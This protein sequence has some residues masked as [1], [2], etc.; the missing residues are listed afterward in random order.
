MQ[1]SN[2][3]DNLLNYFGYT[4]SAEWAFTTNFVTP[5]YESTLLQLSLDAPSLRNT[6]EVLFRYPPPITTDSCPDTSQESFNSVERSTCYTGV[7]SS[8]L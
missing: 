2:S 3:Y 1:Q 5:G 6:D 7:Y 8:R 4:W